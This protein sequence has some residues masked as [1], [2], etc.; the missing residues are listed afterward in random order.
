M[1]MKT[2]IHHY[3]SQQP[4]NQSTNQQSYVQQYWQAGTRPDG[5]PAAAV[6]PSTLVR[7][8]LNHAVG[9]ALVKVG[10]GNGNND[11]ESSSQSQIQIM[12][13]VNLQVG[14]CVSSTAASTR[15]TTAADS[16]SP[17][18]AG[19]VWVSPI[20]DCSGSSG[21]SGS[22]ASSYVALTGH[23]QRILMETLD[24]SQLA[25]LMDSSGSAGGG[26]AWRLV[27]TCTILA[28]N[29]DNGN[30]SG[31]GGDGMRD[32]ILL[33]AVAALSDTKLPRKTTTSTASS[34]KA[35]R[36]TTSS[37]TRA[38]SMPRIPLSL[39]IGYS[40]P[41]TGNDKRPTWWVDPTGLEG[42]ALDGSVTL[43]MVID[44]NTNDKNRDNNDSEDCR[45]WHVEYQSYQQQGGNNNNDLCSPSAF[46]TQHL[47]YLHALAKERAREVRSLLN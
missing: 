19:D 26:S 33:A 34:N 35:I 30:G 24:L 28:N 47:P 17:V 21:S 37:L 15:T 10:G 23:L 32:A 9:S 5:R 45:L 14:Q 27:V 8:I 13:Q 25:I 7:G 16:S 36:Y 1:H 39:T 11:S 22:S 29:Q 38:F 2:T 40:F 43:V 18:I 31:N 44:N 42:T 12:A 3:H 46:A 4:T 20:V 6:R 41:T